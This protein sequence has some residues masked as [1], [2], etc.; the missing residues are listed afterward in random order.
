[1]TEKRIN[2]DDGVERSLAEALKWYR[3]I[4]EEN[5]VAPTFMI[6]GCMPGIGLWDGFI[7]DVICQTDENDVYGMARRGC[8]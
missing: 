4:A 2:C 1:M 8:L 7:I 3:R 6:G 5:T